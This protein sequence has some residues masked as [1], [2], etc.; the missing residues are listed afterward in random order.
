MGG[1]FEALGSLLEASSLLEVSKRHLGPKT[2]IARFFVDDV[3]GEQKNGNVG[4]PSWLAPRDF[5]I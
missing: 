1:S 2:V 3:W 5:L 4:G